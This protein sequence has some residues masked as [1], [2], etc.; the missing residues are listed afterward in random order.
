M[1]FYYPSDGKYWIGT[2]GGNGQLQWSMA[3][4]F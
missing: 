1:M 3:G 4:D 2:L